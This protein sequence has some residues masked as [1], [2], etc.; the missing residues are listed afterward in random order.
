MYGWITYFLFSFIHHFHCQLARYSA[1]LLP[2][3]LFFIVFFFF[4]RQREKNL[5]MDG[6]LWV[7]WLIFMLEEVW[8][9]VNQPS[10]NNV[11]MNSAHKSLLFLCV[12]LSRHFNVNFFIFVPS[13]TKETQRCCLSSEK[14]YHHWDWGK[15]LYK[16]NKC[17]WMNEQRTDEKEIEC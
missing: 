12:C 4:T 15:I 6:C 7:S 2:T 14:E 8:T 16:D 5:C 9:F 11:L 3:F 1:S 10:S 13:H 17:F